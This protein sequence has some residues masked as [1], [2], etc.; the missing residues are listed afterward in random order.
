MSNARL[1]GKIALITGAA[2]GI[3]RACAELFAAEGAKVLATDIQDARG[4]SLA[5]QAP[6]AI[7]YR[8]CDVRDAAAIKTAVDAAV[9]QFGGL[10]ILINN[11]GAPGTIAMLEDLDAEGW[12]DTHAVLLRSVAMG[13]RYGAAAMK[14][15]GG[16]AIINMA[17]AAGV[18]VGGTPIAYT[19][20]K[21]A[22]IH[23]SKAAAIEL[24]AHNIRVNAV[25]PGV[26]AT[27]IWGK[28]RAD[29]DPA[30]ADQI[31]AMVAFQGG[32][33]QPLPRGGESADIAEACLY[34][35]AESG[36]FITGQALGVD[37]G[38]TLG[39]QPRTRATLGGFMTMAP[40]EAERMYADA[41][42][43]ERASRA[44]A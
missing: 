19:T 20:F 40:E 32:K 39:R 42:A 31:A 16:G 34:L 15:R 3:G 35:G 14:A 30:V 37:G 27:P 11:A 43:A 29:H 25:C 36:R 10:D 12:D 41:L 28:M 22:V 17:S 44:K 26:I 7:A 8:H 23:F 4:E 33:F 9:S 2:S 38:I 21:G 13:S 18:L 6:E 1:A 5:A 24:A